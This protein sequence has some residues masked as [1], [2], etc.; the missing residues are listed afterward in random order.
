LKSGATLTATQKQALIADLGSGD[1]ARAKT[2]LAL[3]GISESVI[4][5]RRRLVN[6]LAVQHPLF[7]D[8]A[9]IQTFVED[10][11]ARLSFPDGGGPAPDPLDEIVDELGL[12][13]SGSDEPEDNAACLNLCAAQAAVLAG[14][15]LTGYIAALLGCT[16]SGPFSLFCAFGATAL[17]V[18]AIYE[19]DAVIDRCVANCA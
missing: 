12:P 9:Q 19:M 16:L 5:E 11:V 15:A 8:T 1:Q 4:D 3:M 18:Q 17:Y 14:L 13:S 6:D 2:A 7:K 10:A